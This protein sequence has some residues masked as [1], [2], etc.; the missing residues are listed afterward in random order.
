MLL[1]IFSATWLGPELNRT[2]G[3]P[4]EI[5]RPTSV[6]A[7][8]ESDWRIRGW[9]HPGDSV[10]VHERSAHAQPDY[11]TSASAWLRVSSH[12]VDGW[13]SMHGVSM[14][15]SQLHR[16]PE[17]E[18][19]AVVA[20]VSGM[21]QARRSPATDAA[22]AFEAQVG[23]AL[24][25][26]GRSDDANW[27]T[28]H[29]PHFNW[30]DDAPW[31]QRGW[32]PTSQIRL[33]D[34]QLVADLPK[35]LPTGLSVANVGGEESS[36]QLAEWSYWDTW[37]WDPNANAIWFNSLIPTDTRL[38]RFDFSHSPGESLHGE[39]ADY[40]LRGQVLPA[41]VGGSVLVRAFGDHLDPFDEAII[42]ERDG[43]TTVLDRQRS[44]FATDGYIPYS[45]FAAWSPDARYV[46][47]ADTEAFAGTNQLAMIG[48]GDR[49]TITH[50]LWSNGSPWTS[51]YIYGSHDGI[52]TRYFRNGE[53]DLGFHPYAVDDFQ[54]SA[55]GRFILSWVE[56]RERIATLTS[57][58]G[59][60]I[61]SFQYDDSPRFSAG[62]RLIYYRL[63]D[64]LVVQEVV[65]GERRA[66][67]ALHEDGGY[68]LSPD[69][70]RL[71]YES[72]A[73]LRLARLGQREPYGPVIIPRHRV[74]QLYWS[75][76]GRFFAV[77]LT[78]VRWPAAWDQSDHSATDDGL[79]RGWLRSQIRIYSAD[80]KLIRA[81]RTNTGCELLRWS[82]DSSMIAYGGPS[83]CA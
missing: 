29:N 19:P 8:P 28:V 61:R 67:G 59:R 53:I 79:A 52:L 82:S 35:V 6:H 46:A 23:D 60:F 50:D 2:Y 42:L 64:K 57:S 5:I 54:I 78:H 74:G 51:D 15:R 68:W 69:G 32:L 62:G 34:A 13:I 17:A 27:I 26:Y 3:T 41:P 24:L 40:D 7:G 31:Q 16:L 83:G 39:Q 14:I 20:N 25:V 65:S 38:S 44:F 76:E 77:E 10:R 70:S 56:R 63:E 4:Y 66:I 45:R 1:P 71:V 48:P 22:V 73:G 80:G 47:L 75:P 11:L 30:D 58:D 55:D 12:E 37:A 81:W 21:Q 33:D 72:S 49:F 36:L 18:F 43:S 9:L